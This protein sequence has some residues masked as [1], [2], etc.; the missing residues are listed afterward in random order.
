MRLY[1]GSAGRAVDEWRTLCRG[2][3]DEDHLPAASHFAKLWRT[4]GEAPID[5]LDTANCVEVPLEVVMRYYYRAT[6]NV[7]KVAP[8]GRR[9]S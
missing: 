8:A 6:E 4:F 7:A 3:P 5:C 9:H 2:A 1:D